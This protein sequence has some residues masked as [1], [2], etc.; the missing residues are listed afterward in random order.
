VNHGSQ[1]QSSRYQALLQLLRTADTIWNASRGFFAPWNLSPSQFNVLNLLRDAP[2]GRTQIELGRLLLTHRSNV[3]GLVDRLEERGWVRRLDD[4]QD[5]RAF[6]VV[7]TSA[8]QKLLEE[9][10]LHYHSAAE[11][12][13]GC[14]S[15]Q[16]ATELVKELNEV[17]AHVEAEAA[18]QR[19][20]PATKP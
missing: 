14:L 13:L 15:A 9:I 8:G 6:R 11:R 18:R 5:R 4:E 10:L 19:N 16:R 1:V 17:S 3:T 12:A 2:E 7:L 20:S